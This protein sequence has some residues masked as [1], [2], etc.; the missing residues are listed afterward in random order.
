ME[1]RLPEPVTA[2][3]AL[4]SDGDADLRCP[5]YNN[6][7]RNC[8]ILENLCYYSLDG[9][10]A[11]QPV[12]DGRKKSDAGPKRRGRASKYDY[13]SRVQEIIE[14]IDA[15]GE[16]TAADVYV[17]FEAPHSNARN[18]LSKAVQGVIKMK[19]VSYIARHNRDIKNNPPPPPPP[20]PPT[21]GPSPPPP[22]PPTPPP[23]APPPRIVLS[24]YEGTPISYF[25][26]LYRA[27]IET[28]PHLDEFENGRA[29]RAAVASKMNITEGAMTSFFANN[30]GNIEKAAKINN[31]DKGLTGFCLAILRQNEFIIERLEKYY[32]RKF[33]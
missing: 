26:Q 24:K 27:L 21:G 4:Y 10:P 28:V 19:L 22:A 5:H 17:K 25:E 31:Y 9:M 1:N 15:S 29:F 23:P 18:K 8:D 2:L 16:V 11:I 20:A 7:S 13:S 30:K 33:F 3:L 12:E 6:G 14:F 32:R